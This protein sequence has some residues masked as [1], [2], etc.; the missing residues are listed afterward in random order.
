MTDEE[1]YVKYS[2][3]LVRFATSVVGPS[4]AEDVMVE[5]VL[6]AFGSR[7]W[8]TVENK[9]AYLYRCVLNAGRM[10]LRAAARRRVREARSWRREN[11]PESLKLQPSGS[12]VSPEVHAAM[13]NLSARQRAVIHLT[14]WEDLDETETADCL[15]IAVGSVRQ[16]LHRARRKIGRHLHG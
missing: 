10:H 6:N 8:P 11:L 1:L 12:F 2:D 13:S 15:G 3:S 9:P 16:H 5:G 14:Y 4:D 7:R